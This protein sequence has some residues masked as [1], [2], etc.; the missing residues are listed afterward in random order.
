MTIKKKNSLQPFHLLFNLMVWLVFEQ[1][2]GKNTS[3]WETL[4][5]VGGR[6]LYR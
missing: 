2:E 1:V 6:H 5:Q 3:R 4:V